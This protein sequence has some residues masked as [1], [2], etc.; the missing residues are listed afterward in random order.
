MN[1][2]SIDPSV[3]LEKTCTTLLVVE[4]LLVVVV[5]IYH[6]YFSSSF[7]KNETKQKEEEQKE[8]E[9]EEEKEQKKES[10]YEDKYLER[11]L[12]QKKK[13]L[14]EKEKEKENEKEKEENEKE[15]YFTNYTSSMVIEKT[16]VGNVMMRYNPSRECFEYHSDVTV[17]YRF[18]QVVCRKY[19][20]MFQCVN[21]YIDKEIK[22]KEEP[23]EK[24]EEKGEESQ[25]QQEQQQQQQQQQ[26]QKNKKVFAQFKNYNREGGSGR[27]NFAAPPKNNISNPRQQKKNN[28]P[29]EEIIGNHFSHQGKFANFSFLKVPEMVF[30]YDTFS[31]VIK[32]NEQHV[33][34][35]EDEEEDEKEEKTQEKQE[36]QTSV[37]IPIP[38]KPLSYRD[39]K[40]LSTT[41][42]S[43]AVPN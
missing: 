28:E 33:Q 42:P 18:L 13:Y 8:K 37:P 41:A 2:T 23:I 7:K 30:S 6:V 32:K 35:E 36:K 1:A 31:Y 11:Y 16:P 12:N 20:L 24:K 4:F 3:P 39:F 14:N 29:T 17:P 26:Q 25:Q 38:K 5:T 34:Q 10:P 40:L 43:T 27:V 9:E 15:T 21:L 22:K 19:V